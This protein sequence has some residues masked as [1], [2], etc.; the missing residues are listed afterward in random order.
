VAVQFNLQT[1]AAS[2]LVD[3]DCALPMAGVICKAP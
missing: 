3:A 2:G 1:P